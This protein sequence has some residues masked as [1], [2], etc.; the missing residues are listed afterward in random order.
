MPGSP[1]PLKEQPPRPQ[2]LPCP[3]SPP[4]APN[5][6]SLSLQIFM[7][8]SLLSLKIIQAASVSL[9]CPN[10]PGSPWISGL[11]NKLGSLPFPSVALVHLPWDRRKEGGG[12]PRRTE[13]SGKEGKPSKER[14][15]SPLPV[16]F[17]PH[18]GY[19]LAWGSQNG[20]YLSSR[21]EG[22]DSFRGTGM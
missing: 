21:E 19:N 17:R 12:V 1:A 11:P 2:L 13:A 16:C 6:L 8:T 15:R 20:F 4:P 5:S 9:G 10:K 3:P 18:L 14:G 22:K 7:Q